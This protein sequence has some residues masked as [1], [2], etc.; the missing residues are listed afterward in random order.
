MFTLSDIKEPL[1]ALADYENA[2]KESVSIRSEFEVKSR[3]TALNWHYRGETVSRESLTGQYTRLFDLFSARLRKIYSSQTEALKSSLLSEISDLE[4]HKKK[5]DAEI[6]GLTDEAELNNRK[7]NY[8]LELRKVLLKDFYQKEVLDNKS[9]LLQT[10]ASKKDSLWNWLRIIGD[11]MNKLS[12]LPVALYADKKTVDISTFEISTYYLTREFGKQYQPITLSLKVWEPGSVIEKLRMK[13]LS[14]EITSLELRIRDYNRDLIEYYKLRAFSECFMSS[15]DIDKTY[16]H[17]EALLDKAEKLISDDTAG[18]RLNDLRY[19]YDFI[20]KNNIV[21]LFNSGYLKQI[22]YSDLEKITNEVITSVKTGYPFTSQD[23]FDPFYLASLVHHSDKNAFESFC[24]NK[25]KSVI[26]KILEVQKNYLNAVERL[27][28]DMKTKLASLPK[29]DISSEMTGIAE[30]FPL[31]FQMGIQENLTSGQAEKLL[32]RISDCAK[33]Q[34]Y[35]SSYPS[36]SVILKNGFYEPDFIHLDSTSGKAKTLVINYSVNND[37]KKYLSRTVINILLTLPPGKIKMRIIDFGATNI[38]SLFTTRLNQAFFT[39]DTII[40]ERDL[41]DAVVQWQEKTRRIARKCETIYDYNISRETWLEPYELVIVLGYPKSISPVVENMLR[42]FVE[43]G[44]KSGILFV[45]ANCTEDKTYAGQS[46]L[47]EKALFKFVDSSH[48]TSCTLP[49]PFTPLADIP[50]FLKAAL[51]YL[52]DGI[53]AGMKKTPL[54]QDV[55]HLADHP[56]DNTPISDISVPVGEEDGNAVNFVLDTVSH[57]HTFILGQS[58]TGKSSFLHNIIG[59]ILLKYS[60]LQVELYLLDLKLGGVEFNQY[61]GEK[62]VTALLVDNNDSRVT[63]EI[64]KNLEY[65]MEE[66]SK[67]FAKVGARNLEMYNSKASNPMPQLILVIDECQMIF[68]ERPDNVER[69]IRRII[70]LTA[71]QGR[72]QGV[73]MIFSTQTFMNSA[74]PIDELQGAGLT[75]LYLLNCDRR[76]SEKLANGSSSITSELTTGEIYY[77]HHQNSAPDMRF[78]SYYMTDGQQAAM[79]ESVSAKTKEYNVPQ[80]YYFSGKV[81]AIMDESVIDLL[82]KKSRRSLCVSPGNI[83]SFSRECVSIA[84]KEEAGENI[85]VSGLNQHMQPVRQA[86]EVFLSA[87]YSCCSSGRETEFF[88]IDCLPEDDETPYQAVFDN[89]DAAGIIS[90][91]YGR[92]RGEL[93]KKLGD[94]VRS[95]SADETVIL[96]LGQDKWRELRNDKLLEPETSPSNDSAILKDLTGENTA[97]SFGAGFGRGLSS[98]KK[99]FKSELA[100]LLENGSEQGVHFIIQVDKPQ[101]LLPGQVLSNQ[102]FRNLFRHWLLLKSP[103]DTAMSLRIRDDI[104]LDRLSDDPDRLRAVYYSDDSDTYKYITP[105]SFTTEK[106]NETLIKI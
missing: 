11:S 77:H 70:S 44:Y 49:L 18:S 94:K 72:S 53:E 59:N 60:P 28:E 43:N 27:R 2:Q 29:V 40:G 66:R 57:L 62:H 104:S 106:E 50:E 79:L 92:Q 52:N 5:V 6:T 67:E 61:K 21:E 9:K 96:V 46:L 88:V 51:S 1:S 85:L 73:H 33:N 101:N 32:G 4:K 93:L 102:T 39:G 47:E 25:I 97:R 84:L 8:V 78:K 17:M 71:K 23:F 12:G 95:G 91:V 34:Y 16:D 100:Y 20:C 22:P 24:N 26:D 35:I 14:D 15:S 86:V 13:M 83:L 105:F 89:L 81:Q 56:Y 68:S 87:V 7:V 99:T 65:R 10:I 37:L 63:L 55:G 31:Y 38:A 75:D 76:D 69:E 3:E 98:S 45:F 82:R 54:I 74:I 41:R 48:Q 36:P 90:L 64:L 30:K 42:P 103:S 58:G 19:H 80:Q